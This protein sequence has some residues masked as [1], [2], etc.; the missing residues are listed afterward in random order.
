[1]GHPVLDPDLPDKDGVSESV[2][3]CSFILK[4]K[5]LIALACGVLGVQAD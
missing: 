1:M 5:R 4:T 2:D 3:N